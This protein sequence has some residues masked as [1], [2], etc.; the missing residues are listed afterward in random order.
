MQR[1]L[2]AFSLTL[3]LGVQRSLSAAAVAAP[4]SIDFS[5]FAAGDTAIPNVTETP[6]DRWTITADHK[7]AV[8]ADSSGDPFSQPAQRSA[9]LNITNLAGR[10]F[11][12]S[13]RFSLAEFPA[14]PPSGY[15]AVIGLGAF[16][17][18]SNFFV[19]GNPRYHLMLLLTPTSTGPAGRLNL[20]ES[21]TGGN[22]DVTSTELLPIAPGGIYDLTLRG[23][24]EAGHLD[25]TGIGSDGIQTLSVAASDLTPR[26]GSW[27]GL[28][29]LAANGGAALT[30]DFTRLTVIPEPAAAL[31]AL[32]C[33]RPLLRRR[34]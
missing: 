33:S 16:S 24:F 14:N 30:A 2:I 28:S 4:Y 3:M 27:F 6:S 21:G 32:I 25:L 15:V 31:L 11:E 1:T 20:V 5:T 34:R 12:M 29:A 19:S 7:Y 8:S 13:T 23:H 9:A 26:T 22:F 18:S 17:D 10:D